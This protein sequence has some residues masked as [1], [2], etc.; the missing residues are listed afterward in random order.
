L[1]EQTEQLQQDIAQTRQE[2]GETVEALVHKT[3]VK[4]RAQEKLDETTASVT[5]KADELVEKARSA[6]PDPVARAASET[7]R[8]AREKPAVLVLALGG[9]SVLALL[10]RRRLR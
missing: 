3:D 9:V 4:A 8:T 6:T 2:L 10:A 1:S 5:G 7:S